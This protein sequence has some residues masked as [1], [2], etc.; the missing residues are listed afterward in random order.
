MEKI[1]SVEHQG[2][3]H[4]RQGQGPGKDA[5]VGTSLAVGS[6]NRKEGRVNGR[7]KI[8]A[9]LHP[10]SELELLTTELSCTCWRKQRGV[11]VC[12]GQKFHCSDFGEKIRFL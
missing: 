2:G 12:S 11:F 9:C 10:I 6:R 4:P 3:G 5:M 8:P 1:W 7:G